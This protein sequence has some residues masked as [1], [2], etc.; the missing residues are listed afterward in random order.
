MAR[1]EKGLLTVAWG[2]VCI[3]YSLAYGFILFIIITDVV[4]IIIKTRTTNFV[5]V[6]TQ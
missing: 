4:A 1:E 2:F 3:N 6:F 5:D